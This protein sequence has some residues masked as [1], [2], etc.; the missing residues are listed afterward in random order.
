MAVAVIKRPVGKIILNNTAG[1][2]QKGSHVFF[3]FRKL[4]Q[5]PVNIKPD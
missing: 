1:F 5:S 3:K 4:N 2:E